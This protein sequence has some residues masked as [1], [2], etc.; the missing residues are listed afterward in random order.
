MLIRPRTGLDA[1][2][3]LLIEQTCRCYKTSMGK[4]NK[5][6]IANSHF[7]ANQAETISPSMLLERSLIGALS[8]TLGYSSLV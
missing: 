5:F 1:A 2:D 3:G 7:E 8:L 6:A 4:M